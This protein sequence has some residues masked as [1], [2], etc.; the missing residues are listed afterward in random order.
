M[1][2]K[3]CNCGHKFGVLETFIV[4]IDKLFCSI[5]CYNEKQKE[6]NKKSP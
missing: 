6:A 3:C 5:K 1:E 4:V 2:K